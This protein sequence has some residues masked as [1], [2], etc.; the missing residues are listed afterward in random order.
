MIG[1]SIGIPLG[2]MY[3]FIKLYQVTVNRYVTKN[4]VILILGIVGIA[5]LAAQIAP[6]RGWDLY[7]HYEEIDRIREWGMSYAWNKSRYVGSNYYGATALFYL[8]SLTPWNGTLPFVTIF[9]ELIIYEKIMARYKE[10]ISAQSE[11][12]CFF[13]FLVLSNI[14]MAI[15]GVRNVLAVVL[16][17]YAIWM[18]E[19]EKKQLIMDIMIVLFAITIHPASGFLIMI[20][21]VS[22]IPSHIAGAG[23]AAFILPILTNFLSDFSSSQNAI[24]SSSAGLFALYTKEQAGL[25]LRVRIVSVFLIAFSMLVLLAIMRYENK[26][27]RYWYFVFLYSIG[28]LGM[29]SQG[30]IYSRMLYGLDILYPILIA[31]YCEEA[32]NIRTIKTIYLYKIYCLIYCTG[33]LSFQGYELLRAIIIK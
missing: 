17:N 24:L 32:S 16:V 31:R 14:V 11:G 12:I 4:K 15:S 3:V 2:L 28:T 7:R 18:F 10:R 8:T 23:I 20:Y 27:D 9:L 6:P 5:L 13:L 29:I 26:K 21:A 33:M 30:L 25:D 19:C 1:L 22:Y